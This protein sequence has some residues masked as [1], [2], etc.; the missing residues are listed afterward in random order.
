[1]QGVAGSFE[2]CCN[3]RRSKSSLTDHVSYL[4]TFRPEALKSALSKHRFLKPGP[5]CTPPVSLN[6]FE[7]MSHDREK[8]G[9][10]IERASE[11]T[12]SELNTSTYAGDDSHIEARVVRKLD[13]VVV[14]LLA[15]SMM[16]AYLV[17]DFPRRQLGETQHVNQHRIVATSAMPVSWGCRRI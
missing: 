14:P 6:E 16:M 3:S 11:A 1:M 12:S 9:L 4:G 15:F 8:S 7:K 13:V 5:F 2:G 17:R 10:H